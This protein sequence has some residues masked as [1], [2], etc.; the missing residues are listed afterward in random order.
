M[1][2]KNVE[3]LVIADMPLI[4]EVI[5][6]QDMKRT[7]EIKELQ[8]Q[9]EM[10]KNMILEM[11]EDREPNVFVSAM[12]QIRRM[13]ERW[14]QEQTSVNTDDVDETMSEDESYRHRIGV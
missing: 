13:R 5:K 10:L 4:D 9:V 2:Y 6:K 3:D 11:N 12:D 8:M 1:G 7:I 14:A